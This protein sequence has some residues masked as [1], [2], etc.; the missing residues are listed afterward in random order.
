MRTFTLLFLA[1]LSVV[2]AQAVAQKS[3]TIDPKDVRLSPYRHSE[4]APSLLKRIR[5][6]TDTFEK[7]DGITYDQAV[8]LYKRDLDPES[9]LVLWEEMAKAYKVFCKSRCI[10][11]AEQMDVYR[12]LLLRTMFS[13]DESIKRSKLSVL[14][15]GEARRAMKLY[16]L[17][18][19]PID[20]VQAK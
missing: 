18:P 1:V 8:D 16:R 12:S 9:N 3:V 19:K 7:I 13:E 5:V 14:T 20:V 6:T 15:P 17:P 11:K 4:L 10:A 2:S